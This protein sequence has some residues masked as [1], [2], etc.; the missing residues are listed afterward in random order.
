MTSAAGPPAAPPSAVKIFLLADIRGY[1]SF[2]QE[3]GDEA[4]ARLTTTFADMTGEV[5]VAHYGAVI[6]LKGD[7]VMVG[8]DSPR[9][10]ILAAVALQGRLV[11]C[12]IEEPELPLYVGMGL[13]AGEAVTVEGGYRG[14]ALNLAA[15]LCSLAGPGE[16]LASPEVVHFAGVIDDVHYA[17]HGETRVKGLA[18]P[19]KVIR[20]VP[21]DD[22]AQL[23]TRTSAASAPSIRVALADDSILL[24][25][26]VARLL[27]DTGFHVVAQT[28]TADE[29]LEVIRR[30][31]PDVAVVD[32]RMPPT[33]TDEG[34]RA[35]HE[36]RSEH[37][38]V[39]VMV[40]SQYVE[41]SYAIE[42]FAGGAAGLGYLLKD[43]V[44]DVREFT[45]AV[46]RVGAGGSVID[47][48]VVASLVGRARESSPLETLTDREREVLAL[49]AEGRSNQAISD[50]MF[51]NPK[52]VEGHVRSIFTKLD[53]LPAPDDHRR[54][55]AVLAFLRS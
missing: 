6:D 51:L 16:I 36:I 52:T 54:V 20:V 19:V 9:Q 12:A 24:R 11:Q 47:P 7:E 4:A 5:A 40:L 32:V 43:R 38:E 27:S 17:A 23:L 44:A 53:L 49:M 55:L 33:F 45:D 28:G 21:A 26:G 50:R 1:T 35:A 10:A 46:R 41:T 34:L 48:D 39:G 15:R 3:H 22:P 2:T 13:D 14:G 30:D 25:E 29:L 18:E 42:L 31:P 37:P 8:F